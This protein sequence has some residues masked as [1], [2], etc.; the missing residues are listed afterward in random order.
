MQYQLIRSKRKSIAISFDRDGNLVVK[1]PSWVNL[2]EIEAFV[3]SKQ[4]WIMAT[5]ARLERAKQKAAAQRPRLES[6]DILKFLGEN[7]VLTVIREERSRAKV[8]C[9]MERLLLWVPYEADYEYKRAQLEKWYR[10]QA[11]LVFTQKAEEYAEI[12]GVSFAEIHIKD[13][14]SRWGSCSGR[15]N[16]N[17]NWRLI[18][19]PEPVCDYVIV[20]ELCHLKHMDHSAAFWRLVESVCPYY[21]QYRN[22]LKENGGELYH[23]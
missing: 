15:R 12:L 20:H 11:L 22:W 3:V 18:M 4:E 23:I 14:R 16:L 13:Q 2:K 1:A 8:K 9:V 10:K 21:K 19:A 6:G 7:R 5:A 17:F